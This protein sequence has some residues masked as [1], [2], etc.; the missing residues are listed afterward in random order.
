LWKQ[1]ALYISIINIQAMM[2]ANNI[3]SADYLDILFDGR[4][5]EYGA[6]QLQRNYNKRLFVAIGVVLF[7]CLLA[8]MS[9]ILANAGKQI[10]FTQDIDTITLTPVE[11]SE[12]PIQPVI[13][14]RQVRPAAQIQ[15]TV[16]II[17]NNN[18][19]TDD[20]MPPV[21]DIDDKVIGTMNID[22]NPEPGNRPPEANGTGLAELPASAHIEKDTVFTIVEIPAEFPGDWK[23]FLERNLHY[24]EQAIDNETQGTVRLEFIVDRTG[25]ISEIKALNDPGDGLATEAMRIIKQCPLWRPAEQNGRKVIY[26]HTQTITFQLQ[27]QP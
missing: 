22:G 11:P 26:R 8:I 25:S 24:P 10:S 6:Y 5:K 2:N 7:F 17:V 14:P 15:F 9:S 3:A 1:V 12:P 16:P 27:N 23:R 20:V 18:D 4:N 21:D 19:V 13:P